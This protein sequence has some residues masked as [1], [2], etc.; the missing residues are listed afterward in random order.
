MAKT[1]EG[2]KADAQVIRNEIEANKNTATRVGTALV[3]IIDKVS[4]DIQEVNTNM[5]SFVSEYDQTL[6][7]IEKELNKIEDVTIH[8][9]GVINITSN[10]TT[11]IAQ[12]MSKMADGDIVMFVIG[13]SKGNFPSLNNETR[14]NVDA[15]LSIS[16]NYF[17]STERRGANV[18]D[19]LFVVKKTITLIQ[20]IVCRIIPLND[21]KPNSDGYIG[22]EGI[23][24]V[25]DKEQINKIPNI[26]NTSNR[27]LPKSEQLP[28]K[29][30]TN[31][32]DALQTGVYPWCTLGRP[33]GSTGAYTCIVK[34]T[35]TDDGAYNTIEQTAYGRQGELG[36]VFKRIIFV[37]T[38]GTDNQYG[39]W[40]EISNTPIDVTPLFTEGGTLQIDSDLLRRNHLYYNDSDRFFSTV[41]LSVVN[42]VWYLDARVAGESFDRLYRARIIPQGDRMFVCENV[43]YKEYNI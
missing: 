3:D 32:N 24:T 9:G 35:S 42:R 7:N 23:V 34:R 12:K 36:R 27:A 2:L 25:N 30:A 38:D 16:T 19:L 11:T 8:S 20:R 10:A 41:T 18:G 5:E 22:T 40:V 39:E 37:K 29:W 6:A 17:F 26:E 31:M 13:D 1:Y 4:A 15:G 28:S 43:K 21:A 33:S 14:V